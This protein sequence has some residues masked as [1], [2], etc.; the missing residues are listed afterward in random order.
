MRGYKQSLCLKAEEMQV[1]FPVWR[2]PRESTFNKN[3]I[4]FVAK[5]Q[6]III[7]GNATHKPSLSPE[8]YFFGHFDAIF[9]RFLNDFWTICERFL[10]DFWAIFGRFLVHFWSILRHFLDDLWTI[11][12]IK[13]TSKIHRIASKYTKIEYFWRQRR[14]VCSVTKSF[15]EEC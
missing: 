9:E 3:Y 8:N 5:H 11:F 13:Y 6:N 12:D 4:N 2:I 7:F 14:L 15:R 10:S 1:Q